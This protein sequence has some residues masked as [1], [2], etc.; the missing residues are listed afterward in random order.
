MKYLFIALLFLSNLVCVEASE[1]KN[2]MS[3]LVEHYNASEYQNIFALYND[4]MKAAL[5][6]T[7]STAFFTGLKNEDGEIKSVEFF[8]S[9]GKA[10]SIFKTQFSNSVLSIQLTSDK[11]ENISGLYV[12]PFTEKV[13]LATNKISASETSL[14]EKQLDIII[15]H[16]QLFPNNTQVSIALI[17][18]G[19]VNYFGILRKNDELIEVDNYNKAFEIGSITKVFTSTIL[20]NLVNAGK[21]DLDDTIDN[22]LDIK[23]KG[24]AQISFIEL[25]SHHSGLPRMPSN[26]DDKFIDQKNPFKN[27]GVERLTE[28]LEKELS[29]NEKS[30]VYSNVGV[31]LLGYTLS[32]ISNK[33]YQQ[34]LDEII[35][36]PFKMVNSTTNK[37]TVETILIKGLDQNGE[38]TPNW[39]LNVLSGAGSILST[40][41]DL[42]KFALAQFNQSNKDL[43][44]TRKKT[45]SAGRSKEVGLGWLIIEKLSGNDIYEHN[46]GT[47]GYRSSMVIIPKTQEGIIV[48]SNVSA[49]NRNSRNIGELAYDLMKTLK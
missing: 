43:A 48:L 23:F 42:V 12:F 1:H 20:A 26:F 21:I 4:K 10:T 25:A 9:L 31:G 47:G 7:K 19:K 27:Y 34:L 39:D 28:Y 30:F 41:E 49:F 16:S 44:L 18:A 37:K 33:S 3:Q 17:E 45:N 22:F 46:G 32:K 36:K 40:V 5:P 11:D 29:L 14:S 24:N 35:F 6:L 15:E 13:K 2:L 8:E 38:V